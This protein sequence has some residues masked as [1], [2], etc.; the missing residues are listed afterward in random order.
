MRYVTLSLSLIAAM[1]V[2]TLLTPDAY[3]Q[4]DDAGLKGY[5]EEMNLS[6]DQAKARTIN[7][8]DAMMLNRRLQ[9]EL[10]D[11][12]A[13]LWMEHYPTFKVVVRFTGDARAQLAR[14][15]KDP[16]YVAQSAPRSLEFLLATQQEMAAQ[17]AAAGIKFEGGTDIKT[18]ELTLRVYDA[19]AARKALAKLLS[20]VDFIRI[21]EVKGVDPSKDF[22]Q[23][24]DISGGHRLDG[25]NGTQ[26]CTSGFNVVETA[27]GELGLTTAGHCENDNYHRNPTAR[28]EFKAERDA[29]SFDVQWGAQ[30][31]N[32]TIH[33]QRNE[34]TVEGVQ[35]PI[36]SVATPEDLA[37]GADVCKTGVTTGRTC[38]VIVDPTAITEYNNEIGTY[39]RVSH[40]QGS[41]MTDFG[42]SGGPVYLG[43]RALGL[44]HGRGQG[45]RLND[46]YFMPI[47]LLS[48]LG[49]EPIL[50]PFRLESVPAVS[51]T[52]ASVPVAV[53]FTGHPRFPLQLT[54]ET[55]TC[56]AG[57]ICSDGTT[58]Y[59]TYAPSPLTFNWACTP[60][61]PGEV[62]V[63]RVRVSLKDRSAIVTDTIEADVTCTSL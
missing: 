19:S 4:T 11:S 3:A 58:T 9:K 27:T 43:N 41:E 48:E 12:F 25:Y 21:E 55:V 2:P 45:D 50:A 32:S 38:G 53:N 40:P 17:L 16:R 29:G 59:D 20:V 35:H 46:L 28:V 61:T 15:T 63:S 7:Q 34:I 56:P 14:Y 13:G 30:P 5:A 33:V 51:G 8:D 1:A 44:V 6:V 10:P 36:T 31:S 26:S 60:G 52:G 37:L 24:T 18:S 42:D 23:T 57:W 22:I 39:I 54:L 49:V 47:G 62:K